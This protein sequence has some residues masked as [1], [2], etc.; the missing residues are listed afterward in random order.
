MP[1][2]L[3]KLA[4]DEYVEW[5][6]VVDAP[7]TYAMTRDEMADY[8]RGEYGAHREHET[9]AR[10]DRC[11]ERGHSALWPGADRANCAEAFIEG[12]RAGQNER[13]ASLAE[14]REVYA[15][16]EAEAQA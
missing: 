15:R 7:V 13:E 6:T 2:C 4:D 12:N 10:L 16:R 1:R 11:D 9:P 8:L 5:S 14:L 3:V